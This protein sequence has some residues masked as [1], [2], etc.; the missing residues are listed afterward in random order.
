MTVDLTKLKVGDKIKHRCG[1]LATVLSI[2]LK[3]IELHYFPIIIVTQG[4][5]T[6]SFTVCGDYTALPGKSTWDIIEIIPQRDIE[7]QMGDNMKNLLKDNEEKKEFKKFDGGKPDL[8][9]TEPILEQLYAEASTVGAKKYGRGNYINFTLNDVPRFYAALRRHIGGYRLDGE[10]HGFLYEERDPVDGQRH[11]ASAAW[12]IARLQEAVNRYGY[13][14]VIE[15][16]RGFK[17]IKKE[18]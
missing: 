4:H 10:D 18:D 2:E 7:K 11:L 17:P 12:C 3:P 9:F 5:G 8:S 16:I 6:E 15:A 13:D 1:E 14:A